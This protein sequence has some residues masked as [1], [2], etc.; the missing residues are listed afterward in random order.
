MSN[1]MAGN[2][3]GQEKGNSDHNSDPNSKGNQDEGYR[4]VDLLS[5]NTLAVVVG[6]VTSRV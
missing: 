2:L 6:A 3:T 1:T 4:V 5:S